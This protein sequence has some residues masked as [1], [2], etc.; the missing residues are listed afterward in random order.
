MSMSALERWE[1]AITKS[2]M[3]GAVFQRTQEITATVEALKRVRITDLERFT[4]LYERVTAIEEMFTPDG[5]ASRLWSDHEKRLDAL[6]QQSAASGMDVCMCGH[7]R[8]SHPVACVNCNCIDFRVA[9]PPAPVA[10]SEDNECKCGHAYGAHH[11]GYDEEYPTYCLVKGCDC[12]QFNPTQAPPSAPEAVVAIDPVADAMVWVPL[13]DLKR[14]RDFMHQAYCN[15]EIRSCGPFLREIDAL[16][17]GE[18]R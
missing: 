17:A 11:F 7:E 2:D 16:I 18:V 4:K 13:G 6:E 1:R 9:V 12:G 10:A 14:L 3:I 5:K 8:V 15:G